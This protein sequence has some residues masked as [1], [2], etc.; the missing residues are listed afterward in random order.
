MVI[1]NSERYQLCAAVALRPVFRK[2]DYIR[3]SFLSVRS[4]DKNR[5]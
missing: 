2:L 3:Q 1:I 5:L 4:G